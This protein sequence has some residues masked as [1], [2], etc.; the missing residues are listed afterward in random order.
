LRRNNFEAYN[1]QMN[2]QDPYDAYNLQMNLQ[3]PYDAYI[4]SFLVVAC[5]R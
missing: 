1:M 2:L 3:D 4:F 5:P